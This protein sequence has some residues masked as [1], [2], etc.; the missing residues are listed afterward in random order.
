MELWIG[1]VIPIYTSVGSSYTYGIALTRSKSS[2]DEHCI[3]L[4]ST[5]YQYFRLRAS[6]DER[7][8]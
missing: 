5:F 8:V 7:C 2:L 6:T 1:F 4:T 3:F